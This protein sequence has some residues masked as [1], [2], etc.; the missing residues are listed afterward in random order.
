MA[1]TVLETDGT[2]ARLTLNRPERHNSLVPG[3]VDALLGDLL[4]VRNLA[5]LRVLVLQAAGRSFS[6]GGDVAGFHAVQ[7]AD[8]PAYAAGLVGRLHEA[9]LTLLDLPVPV[10]GRIQGPVTGGALGLVLA[11]DLTAFSPAAFVQPYYAEVGFS[12]DGGWTAML[13]HRIGTARAGEIQFLNRR[14]SSAE[15]RDLGIATTVTDDL[16][17]TVTA[18]IDR[19]L[20]MQ[21]DAVT[22]TKRL[23]AAPVR[24]AIVA[25]LVA[26]QSEF[27]TQIGG[28]EAGAGM[29]RFL[30]RPT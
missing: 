22:R 12:P 5:G 1:L 14:V 8:R 25:G 30:A 17:G 26:E 2:V 21:R 3:L 29:I 24:Q 10:L 11:C 7:Q 19:I 6:T 4:R 9:I 28:A 27:V 15:A 23:L 16:D 18:W 20:S 13:P